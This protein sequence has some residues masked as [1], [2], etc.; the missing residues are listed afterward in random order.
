MRSL[1]YRIPAIFLVGVLVASIVAAVLAVRLFQDY[2]RDRTLSELRRQ[3]QGLAQL[4]QEQAIRSVDE[5]RSAPGFAAPILEEAT[6]SRIYYAGVE[7]FP[8]ETSGL[9]PLSVSLLNRDLL[10]AGKVQTFEFVP[11]DTDRTYFAAAYP[12]MLGGETFGALVVAKPRAELQE[13]WLVLLGRMAIA[14]VVGLVVAAGLVWYLSRRLTK[15]VLALSRAADEVAAGRYDIELPQPRTTDE[16]GHLTERFAE[17]TQ[18]LAASQRRERNFLMVVSHELR[19]PLTAIR[20]HVDALL[21]G[22][23]QDEETREASLRV[24]GA[25]SEQLARLVGDVLDLARME[26]DQFTLEEDE[27]ELRRL[28]EQ[29]YESFG[30]EARR[31]GIEYDCS[32]DADPVLETDGDRMLQI[33]SNLLDNAFAWTPDGGRVDL[34]LTANNGTIAVSV[35]DS[36]PGIAPE[37]RERIFRPFWSR[38]GSGTGL[39]LPIALEL[40]HALGGELTLESQ[41]GKGSTFELR[42]PS[43]TPYAATRRRRRRVS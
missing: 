28:L 20:G 31:R 30:E 3:A 35:S 24:I 10:E 23:A 8:G 18:T 34:R 36:G 27:V 32:L 26:A 39:G 29:A 37:E 17:M 12:I 42:L 7:I 33:V 43:P 19:T 41:I 14:L 5:A 22:V 38:A 16:I 40:A 2:T 9:R 11:P 21:E 25:E 15:P 6:G 13:R 4:Y 1:R